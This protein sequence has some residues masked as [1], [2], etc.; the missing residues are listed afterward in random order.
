MSGLN[1]RPSKQT[2]PLE[3][4]A[5]EHDEWL[6]SRFWMSGLEA[7]VWVG[8]AG[9]VS[10]LVYWATG[11]NLTAKI[12]F[13]SLVVVTAVRSFV[14]IFVDEDWD[15]NGPRFSRRQGFRRRR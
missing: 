9:V 14:R 6:K 11:S 1:R 13:L 3:L 7:Y 12:I 4:K 5:R 15:E 8:S 10:A 2:D